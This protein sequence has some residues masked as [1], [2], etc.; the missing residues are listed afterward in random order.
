MNYQELLSS[1]TPDIYQRLKRAVE[2]GKWPDGNNLSAE[3]RQ[4]CMEAI[5][6]FEQKNLPP[7]ERTGYIPPKPGGACA[8][9][10]TDAEAPLKWR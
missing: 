4:L 2:L 5:I 9:E 8:T 10:E 7:E 1:V 3:Q 6:V